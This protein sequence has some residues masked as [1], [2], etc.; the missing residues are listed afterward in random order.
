MSSTRAALLPAPGTALR[1]VDLDL[2]PPGP[3]EV[4]VRLH[5]SGVCTD[6]LNLLDGTVDV[7][8]PVVPGHEG[9]GIV[10]EVGSDVDWLSVGDHV[11]LSWA[12]YCG[13]CEQCLRDLPHLCGT[14]WPKMLA[15]GMLDG[16]TRLRFGGAH[17]HHYCF[18]SSFAERAVVPARSCVRIAEDVPFEVAALLGC[19]VTSGVGA[20]WR[21]AAVRPGERVA[22][23]GLGG[24]GLSV[25]L[26]ALAAGVSEVIAVD[27]RPER[28]H[29]A[30]E[31][32][33]THAVPAAGSP[34]E[35]A[36]AVV[37]ASKG[38]VD[39]AFET[40]ARPAAMRS[41][42]LSTRA[43]GAAVLLGIPRA[44]AEISLPALTIPRMERRVLGSIYGSSRPD[45][46]F[47]LILDEYRRGRLPID[48]LI[49]H[50]LPLD[51]V[52]LAVDA[53]RSGEATRVVLQLGDGA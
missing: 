38:G 44:D 5:A 37:E 20:V 19:A 43:R 34:E 12:P 50:R 18:L 11:A 14:A 24:T 46:D 53:V 22:V 23:F 28:L 6:D 16:T 1:V 10:E 45:R 13:H 3:G 35:I 8:S 40:S 32:G 52:G 48:K 36:D 30:L 27:V 47:P 39:Y 2:E 51:D 33:A 4:L 29:R 7:P 31:L 42:F 26:G 41:A 9:A 49:T 21:T 15:G 25:V 17:V